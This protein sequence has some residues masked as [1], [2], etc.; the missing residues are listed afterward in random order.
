[1]ARLGTPVDVAG[2]IDFLVNGSSYITGQN[3]L[4]DGGMLMY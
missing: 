1:M 3:Y 4:V 2:L